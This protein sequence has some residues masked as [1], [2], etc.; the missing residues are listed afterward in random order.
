MATFAIQPFEAASAND[1]IDTLRNLCVLVAEDETLVSMEIVEALEGADAF[2]VGPASCLEGAL[3]LIH[4]RR[5][6]AAIL[7]VELQGKSIYPAADLLTARGVPFVFTTGHDA[8]TL[9]ER[10]AQ[11][12]ISAKPAP[13]VDALSALAGLIG[14][15]R[16]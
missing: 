2:A 8:E 10:F 16:A 6:D 7:D 9:P 4:T 15:G 12:P 14:G 11:V 1:E 13:A 5:V 3:D